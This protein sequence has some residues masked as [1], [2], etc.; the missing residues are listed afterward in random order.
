MVPLALIPTD[1]A[2]QTRVRV[3]AAVVRDYAAAMTGQLADGGLRFPPVI[4]FTDDQNYCL[5]DGFHREPNEAQPIWG[6]AP[7]IRKSA[8]RQAAKLRRGEQVYEMNLKATA[9]VP[10]ATGPTPFG[11]FPRAKNAAAGAGRRGPRSTPVRGALVSI[12]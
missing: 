1:E 4:L 12:S 9:I 5:G 10:T 3:S 6:S 8:V 7:D 11:L 2:A